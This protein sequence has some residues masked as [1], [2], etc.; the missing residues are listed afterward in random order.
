MMSSDT[1]AAFVDI[2]LALCLIH[3]AGSKSGTNEDQQYT[4]QSHN[5]LNDE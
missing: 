2:A 5:R 1:D 4:R 3:A